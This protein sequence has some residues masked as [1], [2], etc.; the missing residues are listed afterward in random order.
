MKEKRPQLR[1]S[2]EEVAKS[3]EQAARAATEEPI[4]DGPDDRNVSESAGSGRHDRGDRLTNYRHR[5]KDGSDRRGN[6]ARA[7]SARGSRGCV[8]SGRAQSS[9]GFTA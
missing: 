7:V 1:N 8:V 2:L 4:G 9:R 3:A 5:S 6:S